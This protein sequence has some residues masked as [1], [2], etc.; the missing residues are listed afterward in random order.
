MKINKNILNFDR[1][2][3]LLTAWSAVDQ[4]HRPIFMKF[5]MKVPKWKWRIARLFMD[6]PQRSRNNVE[7]SIFLSCIILWSLP[8]SFA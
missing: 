3:I 8:K 7:K 4:T 6:N 5:A 2:H 1:W